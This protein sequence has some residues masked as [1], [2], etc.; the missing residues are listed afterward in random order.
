M[1]DNDKVTIWGG[2][3]RFGATPTTGQVIAG[4][5]TGFVIYDS[6]KD[7]TSVVPI[8]GNTPFPNKNMEL[9]KKTIAGVTTQYYGFAGYCG[10]Y[11]S[12]VTQANLTGQN[13]V[14]FDASSIQYGVYLTGTP[15]TQIAVYS[16][17]VY[18][19]S[20]T[21]DFYC[22]DVKPSTSVTITLSGTAP[23]NATSA[24]VSVGTVTINGPLPET[25]SVSSQTADL[26][27]I[28][29]NL[30]GITT[31]ALISWADVA[32]ETY[33]SVWIRKNG[34]DVPWSKRAYS[35]IGDKARMVV[36]IEYMV[37]LGDGEYVEL[38]WESSSANTSLYSAAVNYPSA[39]INMN[40]VR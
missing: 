6:A 38:V 31:T 9:A 33:L 11:Y 23:L 18:K 35:L 24:P 12:D 28:G 27:G 36:A 32:L 7:N 8:P 34:V 40:M 26:T 10:S 17:G 1:P 15:T 20:G 13:L 3:P 37:T 19:I 14:S 25:D 5:G 4:G 29:A 21:L 22:S 39:I 2:V 30:S 16:A